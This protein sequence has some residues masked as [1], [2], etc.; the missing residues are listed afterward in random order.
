[1]GFAVISVMCVVMG[2]EWALLKM[3]LEL[4][5]FFSTI[6]AFEILLIY[7]I[8]LFPRKELGHGDGEAGA[9]F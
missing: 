8:E 9:R 1:M 7:T 4:V 6:T 3:R 5:S 2:E